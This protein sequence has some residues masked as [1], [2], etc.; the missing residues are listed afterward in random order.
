MVRFQ[1]WPGE[2]EIRLVEI[3]IH[4]IGEWG[5]GLGARPLDSTSELGNDNLV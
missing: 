3:Q 4:Q 1:R 2:F 5:R